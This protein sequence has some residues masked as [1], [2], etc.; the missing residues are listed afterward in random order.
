MEKIAICHDCDEIIFFEEE[1][2][3]KHCP[4]C[5]K[6]LQVLNNKSNDKTDEKPEEI[7]K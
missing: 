4:K 5:G 1:I 3:M 2:D 6:V 7:S